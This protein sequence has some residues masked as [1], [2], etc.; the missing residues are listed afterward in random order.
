MFNFSIGK[1]FAYAFR[2]FGQ[3]FT[4]TFFLSMLAAAFIS[5]SQMAVDYYVIGNLGA[6]IPADAA[7]VSGGEYYKPLL[8]VFIYSC[9]VLFINALVFFMLT[10]A[11]FPL[12]LGGELK[13]KN[14]F[15]PISKIFKFFGGFITIILPCGFA[16]LIFFIVTSAPVTQFFADNGL[17]SVL[18]IVPFLILVSGIVVS[19]LLFRYMFFYFGIFDAKTVSESFAKSAELTL[20]KRNKLFFLAVLLLIINYLGKILIIGTIITMPLSVLALIYAYLE[21]S[22]Q[23]KRGEEAET[24]KNELIK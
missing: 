12:C 1:A 22:A 2:F 10:A 7:T 3:N 23:R 13:L 18:I 8:G 19:A 15:P 14:F 17:L 5:I 4:G 16:L 9:V 21:L 24:M 6:L 20:G 11:L